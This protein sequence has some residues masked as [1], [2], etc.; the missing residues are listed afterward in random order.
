[1]TP[2][3]SIESVE[4]LVLLLT[5][6]LGFLAWRQMH[7][8]YAGSVFWFLASMGTAWLAIDEALDVHER[9]GHH[10][11]ELGVRE[12][13]GVNHLDDLILIAIAICALAVIATFWEELRRDDAV[14]RFF[15]AGLLV[16]C[17][18]ITWDAFASTKGSASWWFEES[19]EVLAGVMMACA[20]GLKLRHAHQD[21]S[22]PVPS[23]WESQG[24]VISR[25]RT[26]SG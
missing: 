17:A 8:T 10:L 11:Y 2:R 9:L 25:A 13:A 7:R 19:I 24:V 3:L 20:F 16:F 26:R 5:A 4:A 14:F 15:A 18:A 12:P 6:V 1:L 23:P 22:L 21:V